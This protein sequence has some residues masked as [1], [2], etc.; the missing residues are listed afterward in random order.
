MQYPRIPQ[1][2]PDYGLFAVFSLVFRRLRR[3]IRASVGLVVI[4]PAP[5]GPFRYDPRPV[6]PPTDPRRPIDFVVAT[7]NHRI[8]TGFQSDRSVVA[9]QYPGIPQMTPDGG[10]FALFSLVFRRLRRMILASTGL[11]VT[12]QAPGRLFHGHARL[13]QGTASSRIRRD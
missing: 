2:D 9:L 1:I 10:L 7:Q 13:G 5:E 11:V 6:R 8:I 4:P 12:P 3:T